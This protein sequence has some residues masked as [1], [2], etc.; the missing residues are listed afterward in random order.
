M[1]FLKRRFTAV[2]VDLLTIPISWYSAYWLRFNARSIPQD[3]FLQALYILPFL[4]GIQFFSFS[5]FGLYRGIW[6]FASLPDF[7][8]ILKSVLVGVVCSV[9]VL[10]FFHFQTPRVVIPIYAWLLV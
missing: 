10:F 7:I 4:I 2:L 1:F 6:G 9:I 5:F 3:D 8:R